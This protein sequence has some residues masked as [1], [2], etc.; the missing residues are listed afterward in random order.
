[1]TS[2]L[3]PLM[4]L[5]LKAD[6]LTAGM[7]REF[8]FDAKR[9]WRFDFAWPA[10]KVALEVEGGIWTSGRHTTATGWLA[11]AEKYNRAVILGWRVLRVAVN[12]VKSGEASQW[13]RE[14]L[15]VA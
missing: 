11:D 8:R 10:Q 9:R 7:E 12:Q 4:L 6:K 1:M 13:V 3:E 15:E 14:L 2:T 5:H